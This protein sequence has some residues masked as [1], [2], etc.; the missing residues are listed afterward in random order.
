MTDGDDEPELWVLDGDDAAEL[1]GGPEADD[2]GGDADARRPG[3]GL[4][5]SSTLTSE[6]V[7]GDDWADTAWLDALA[8]RPGSRAAEPVAPTSADDGPPVDDGPDLADLEGSVPPID[9]GWAVAEPDRADDTGPHGVPD[10][11][12]TRRATTSADEFAG[13]VDP[14]TLDDTST[15]ASTPPVDVVPDE[16][17]P[18]TSAARPSRQR[19]RSTKSGDE[20]SEFLREL[21]RLALDED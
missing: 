13:L 7:A 5:L 18:T 20:V 21:S 16:P 3:A 10:G 17:A 9:E 11:S 15:G 12:D 8:P 1:G 2:D 6:D 4:E 14:I 19:R